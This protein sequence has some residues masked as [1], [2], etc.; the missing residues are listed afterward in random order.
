MNPLLNM[1]IG[2]V[3]DVI[4]KVIDRAWPDPTEAAKIKAQVFQAQQEFATKE[5]DAS[6]QLALQQMKVNEAEATSGNWYAAGWR[7][8]VGYIGCFALAWQY[9]VYP[10][11]NY[12]MAILSPGFA[13]P[14]LGDLSSLITLL[15]G[16]LGIG[17]MR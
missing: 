1:L 4:G 16:M 3:F 17:V 13:P 15:G 2:P 8:T 7:P 11:L 9:I 12:F 10:L 6:L 14:A 5:L